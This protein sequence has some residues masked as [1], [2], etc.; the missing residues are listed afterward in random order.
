MERAGK[1]KETNINRAR[2]FLKSRIP[3]RAAAQ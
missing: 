1:L 3:M 2:N